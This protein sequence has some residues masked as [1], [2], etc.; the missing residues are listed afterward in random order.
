[1]IQAVGTFTFTNVGYVWQFHGIFTIVNQPG[2]L[3]LAVEVLLR[4]KT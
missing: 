4:K 1:M 3:F 2:L